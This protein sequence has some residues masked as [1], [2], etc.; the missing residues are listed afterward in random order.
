[1]GFYLIQ[2]NHFYK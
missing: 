2:S 1:M